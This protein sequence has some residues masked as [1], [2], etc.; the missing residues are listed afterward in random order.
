MQKIS[1]GN[2]ARWEVFC[3]WAFLGVGQNGRLVSVGSGQATAETELGSTRAEEPSAPRMVG[4]GTDMGRMNHMVVFSD[5][6]EFWITSGRKMLM[7]AQK[8]GVAARGG[9][10]NRTSAATKQYGSAGKTARRGG[11]PIKKEGA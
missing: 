4:I 5:L 7:A 1:R 9:F 2:K 6:R 10:D 8:R 11:D 3:P